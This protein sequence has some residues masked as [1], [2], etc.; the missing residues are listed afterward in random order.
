MSSLLSYELKFF[1]LCWSALYNWC[2]ALSSMSFIVFYFT[3]VFIF[4]CDFNMWCIRC[5]LLTCPTVLST[6]MDI[7]KLIKVMP[8][9]STTPTSSAK[10]TR[11]PLNKV[12]LEWWMCWSVCCQTISSVGRTAGWLK[13]LSKLKQSIS[14]TTV[15]T[16]VIT[17]VLRSNRREAGKIGR[18]RC[19]CWRKYQTSIAFQFLAVNIRIRTSLKTIVYQRRDRGTW[20]KTAAT[21]IA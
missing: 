13:W 5:Y 11:Q 18:T 17:F 12:R 9:C 2:V 19:T 20:W 8:Y 21:R 6:V 10:C 4:L 15:T 3:M 1:I 16:T 14:T 7:N